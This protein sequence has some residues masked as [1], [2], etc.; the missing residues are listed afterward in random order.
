MLQLVSVA[1]HDSFGSSGD[2]SSYRRCI[3][4]VAGWY[5]DIDGR[6][7]WR[8]HREHILHVLLGYPERLQL[9]APQDSRDFL[10][11]RPA[12]DWYQSAMSYRIEDLAWMA[13]GDDQT[14][15]PNVRVN[16]DAQGGSSGPLVSPPRRRA[17]P[18][19]L[20][21]HHV[22]SVVLCA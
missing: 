11:Q 5:V 13:V 17:R 16:D 18:W 21:S 6:Q 8:Q 22:V 10:R 7:E 20:S 15:G 3:A 12:R 9:R 1:G 4:W 2:G 19:R 14:G